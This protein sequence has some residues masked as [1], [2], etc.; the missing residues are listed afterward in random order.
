MNA[1]IFHNHRQT[2]ELWKYELKLKPLDVE[3]DVFRTVRDGLS[4]IEG[5]M[6]NIIILESTLKL[7]EN[8]ADLSGIA[9]NVSPLLIGGL[10]LCNKIRV[11]EQNSETPI[12]YTSFKREEEVREMLAPFRQ[13]PNAHF[14]YEL[15]GA[16]IVPLVQKVLKLS[17]QQAVP[18]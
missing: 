4:A 13:F 1:L 9:K 5:S 15:D 18:K 8:E 16:G 14:F 3:S 17:T 7:S 6:H 10:Y 11:S 2:R 12:I